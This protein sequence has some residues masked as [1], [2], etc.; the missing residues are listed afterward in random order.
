MA[1]ESSWSVDLGFA[2]LYVGRVI[3][4]VFSPII[5]LTIHHVRRGS[6]FLAEAPKVARLLRWVEW[7]FWGGCGWS[8]WLLLWFHLGS[9]REMRWMFGYALTLFL[10]VPL[11]G[12]GIEL[13]KILWRRVPPRS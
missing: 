9:P 4:M 12:L 13:A 11:T 8:A 7:M 1:P 10:I 3:M 5:A 2:F 6:D